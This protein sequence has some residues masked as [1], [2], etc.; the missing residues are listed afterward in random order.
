MYETVTY[1]FDVIWYWRQQ[2]DVNK[3]DPSGNTDW[4]QTA[5]SNP[6]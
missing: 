5:V 1:K 4:Y 2:S 6:V 3:T